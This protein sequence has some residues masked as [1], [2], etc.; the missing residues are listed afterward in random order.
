MAEQ[1]KHSFIGFKILA[2]SSRYMCVNSVIVGRGISNVFNLIKLHPMR[3]VKKKY[4]FVLR[5]LTQTE[6]NII[7]F[8]FA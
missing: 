2:L 1:I 8:L 3:E 6:K 4:P 7:L 5:A